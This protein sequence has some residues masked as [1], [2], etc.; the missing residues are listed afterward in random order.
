M[1]SNVNRPA[2]ATFTVLGIGLLAI[3]IAWRVYEGPQASA[4]HV[5]ASVPVTATPVLERAPAPWAPTL[6]SAPAPVPTVTVSAEPTL[7]DGFSKLTAAT[8]GSFAVSG[9]FDL[10]LNK[11]WYY[12]YSGERRGNTCQVLYLTDWKAHAN[13]TAS[14][15]VLVWLPCSAIGE[16]EA[17]PV[18]IPPTYTPAP[19]P[20]C[21]VFVGPDDRQ[22]TVCGWTAEDRKAQAD[23]ILRERYAGITAIPPNLAAT[24]E[25]LS[26]MQTAVTTMRANP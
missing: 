4:L 8:S 26:Q 14:G 25:A 19:Q 20:P 5:A 7:P 6:T 11:D 10:G 16:P 9:P 13:D 22:W 17:T 3:A 21:V 2:L 18:P 24:D 23:V 12:R 15:S 1:P